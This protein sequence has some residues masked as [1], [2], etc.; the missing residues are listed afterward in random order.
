VQQKL[1]SQVTACKI[2]KRGKVYRG[3]QDHSMPIRHYVPIWHPPGH[4]TLSVPIAHITEP[5][6]LLSSDFSGN[7]RVDWSGGGNKSLAHS[8]SFSWSD[9]RVGVNL[10]RHH[11]PVTGLILF[12]HSGQG[13]PTPIRL[14]SATMASARSKSLDESAAALTRRT[15]IP[16]T[17][18]PST[19]NSRLR[20]SAFST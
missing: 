10:V 17:I 1:P 11:Q 8:R 13:V 4:R 20:I 2:T 3:E 15:G 19:S 6:Q 9:K 5:L 12:P 7:L 18:R 14:A 16:A